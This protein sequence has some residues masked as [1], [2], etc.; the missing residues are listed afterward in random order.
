MTGSNCRVL[1]A[2]RL[3]GQ[4]DDAIQQQLTRLGRMVVRLGGFQG[5][6]QATEFAFGERD[7]DLFLGLELVID[8]RLGDADG[9]GDHCSEVRL[10]RARR[11]SPAR[12]PIC[13]CAALRVMTR[14]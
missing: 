13:T 11:S 6:F 4:L 7:D 2:P 9:V 10:R 8:G 14:N 5:P 3:D 1:A 12:R